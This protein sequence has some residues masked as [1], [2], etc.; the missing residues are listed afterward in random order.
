MSTIYS[1]APADVA[2]R[3]KPLLEKFH[4]E[5]D[6]HDVRVDFIFANASLDKA[7]N[8]T[9]PAVSHQGYPAAAI[10]RI[11]PI[12]DRVMGRG[13]CEVVIDNDLWPRL[14]DEEKD[15]LL[16]HELEHFELH[17]DKYG[18]PV[19]DDMDRPKLRMKKHDH[20]FGWF[21]NIARRYGLASGEV[22]Q[23]QMLCFD[24]SGQFYL[25]F[26]GVED[27]DSV[28]QSVRKLL[29]SKA[30]VG[31]GV[32]DAES[33]AREFVRKTQSSLRKEGGG[34]VKI[35]SGGKGVEITKDAVTAVE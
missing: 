32:A 35:T 10:A 27:H 21:D 18:E 33:P 24:E 13:D 31:D 30:P 9:G 8:K 12:K 14:S 23:F 1:R 11:V 7:G 16:D 20:Q 29:G 4:F 6:Q 34:S 26:I 19:L 28:K 22:K 2:E 3:A 25:P 17:L 5:L 15:G